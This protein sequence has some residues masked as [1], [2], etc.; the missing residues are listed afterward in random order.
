ME[1]SIITISENGVVNAPRSSTVWM[2]QYEIADLLGVFVPK[3]G[4]GIRSILKSGVLWK[5]E[6]CRMLPLA[7]GNSVEVYSWEVIIALAFR[8]DSRNACLFREW[9]ATIA[10]SKPARP[11]MRMFFRWPYEIISGLN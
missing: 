11:E 10:S 9:L 7:N 5:H 4:A 1:R 3:V 2:T 8:V 6:T